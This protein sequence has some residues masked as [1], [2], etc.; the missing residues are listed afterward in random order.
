MAQRWNVLQFQTLTTMPALSAQ[1]FTAANSSGF[2]FRLARQHLEHYD[3]KPVGQINAGYDETGPCT[4]HM[5]A[6]Q[7]MDPWPNSQLLLG[8]SLTNYTATVSTEQLPPLKGD[9]FCGGQDVG[10]G[11]EQPW[12]NLDTFGGAGG[13]ERMA[14]DDTELQGMGSEAS[15]SGGGQTKWN[16]TFKADVVYSH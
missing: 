3:Y 10:P 9:L 8:R 6:Q 14:T 4:A 5:R 11:A 12:Q 2:Y 15:P 16:W 13:L 7:M 1:G